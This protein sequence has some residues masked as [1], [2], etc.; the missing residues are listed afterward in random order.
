VGW[1]GERPHWHLKTPGSGFAQWP[2]PSHRP[3]H[4]ATWAK[5]APNVGRPFSSPAPNGSWRSYH[6]PRKRLLETWR[7]G[8]VI[9]LRF[10]AKRAAH[11]RIRP[12]QRAPAAS[13]HAH[14]RSR[15]A[16]SRLRLRS[17]LQ[18][19]RVRSAL[20]QSSGPNE[21]TRS[22]RRFDQSAPAGHSISAHLRSPRPAPCPNPVRC[23]A[24]RTSLP[25]VQRR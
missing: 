15:R 10:S 4:D 20:P 17:A 22:Q 13:R 7:I 3:R 14:E 16:R 6:P 12:R 21:P 19:A 8:V 24:R 18:I 5:R 9:Q 25:F 23:S 2:T 11:V 1:L